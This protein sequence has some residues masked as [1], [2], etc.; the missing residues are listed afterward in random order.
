MLERVA[1][2]AR[3]FRDAGHDLYLV[4][5]VVRDLVLGRPSVD[6]DLTTDAHPDET[7]A[8][9]GGWADERWTQ[10]ERFGTIG[11]RKDGH[12]FEITTY[13]AEVYDPTSR[14]PMV[15]F[16]TTLDGDLVRRDFTINAMAIDPLE[17]RLVDPH[18]GAGDLAA[19]RLRTP[20]PPQVSFDD[21]PL[22]MLRAARF[23]A[24]F[25]LT[26][27]PDVLEAMRH[28][29]PR[30]AI[31]SAERIHD[32]LGKLLGGPDPHRGLA[33]LDEVGLLHPVLP[34]AEL[35]REV[36]GRSPDDP[37]VR[38]ALVLRGT[39]RDGLRRRLRALRFSN[40]ETATVSTIVELVERGLDE[41]VTQ[42]PMLRRLR[43]DAGERLDRVLDAVRSIDPE[44]GASLEAAIGAL[45]TAEPPG[46]VVRLDGGAVKAELDLPPGPAIGEALG[47]LDEALLDEGPLSAD[48][49]LSRLREW[50]ARRES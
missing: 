30:L 33:L 49:Q 1:P 17:A 10:G 41:G 5:G 29:A 40:D 44:R 20:G 27:E 24:R 42:L 36:L 19:R 22:R 39:D 9:L 15:E 50:W 35:D 13:R 25:D 37:L 16:G 48:E 21:D 4:G 14:K 6:L 32:E 11:C 46:D 12:D 43:R 31:V 2:L 26:V 38:L 8:I 45:V 23:A 47:V 28:Q 3:R 7:K 18:D 34:E